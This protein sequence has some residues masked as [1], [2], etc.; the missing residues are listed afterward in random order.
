MIDRGLKF[1]V[2]AWSC[3]SELFCGENKTL[4]A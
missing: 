4:L 3:A 1:E 2:K